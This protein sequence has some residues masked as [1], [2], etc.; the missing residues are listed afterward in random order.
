[1]PDELDLS[2]SEVEFLEKLK[3]S[4]NSVVFKVS[5]RGTNMYHESR[6]R[7]H[8]RGP[9]EFDPPDREVNLFISEST[10]YHRLQ[11]KGL[12]NRGIIPDFYG[13]IRNIQPALWLNLHM[14]LHDKLPP[15]AI[16]I[17]YIPNM[18]AVD[19]SNYSE[20]RLSSLRQILDEIHKANVLHGDTKPR[21][22]MVF[23]GMQE[24][25]LWIDFDSAQTFPEGGLS[26]K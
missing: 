14:F 3:E 20:Q 23:V 4:K 10:A 21:N 26:E 17:E 6:S 7:Y 8:D 15:N 5:F 13:T 24:R 2:P 16:L 1:M 22:M 11:S 9:S 25:V 18:Q 19:L 12:C